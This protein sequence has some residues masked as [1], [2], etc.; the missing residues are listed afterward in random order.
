M[1]RI[2]LLSVVTVLVLTLSAASWAAGGPPASLPGSAQERAQQFQQA[3]NAMR[4]NLQAMNQCRIAIREMQGEIKGLALQIR[5]EIRRI[6]DDGL[7]MSEEQLEEIRN[8]TV[9][10]RGH[11]KSLA[12]TMGQIN[13]QALQ[14]RQARAELAPGPV[15]QALNRV[16]AV[17]EARLG[18]LEGIAEAMR[19]VRALLQAIR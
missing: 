15:S 14:M 12:E 17:Q 10:M 3:M 19:T 2:V 18:H 6:R 4:E 11:G 1:R 7:P 9:K 5:E 16:Q 13:E 8:L